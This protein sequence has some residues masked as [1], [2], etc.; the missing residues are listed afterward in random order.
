MA[1]KFRNIG[2]GTSSDDKDILELLRELEVSVSNFVTSDIFKRDIFESSDENHYTETF[3]KFF[4]NT[5]INSR[6]SLN[7]QVSLPKRRS[8]DI[9]IYLKAD[10]EHYIFNIEAKFLPSRDYVSGN[11][12]AIER[13][14][15]CVHGLSNRNP[16]KCKLL[17][18]SSIIAYKRN[19]EFSSHQESINKEIHNLSVNESEEANNWEESEKLKKVY[20]KDTARL[21]SIHKRE[22]QKQITLHHFWVELP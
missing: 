21:K 11:Y 5:Y 6:F 14:K 3:V 18:Q 16:E 1:I 8:A 9:G 12:S 22:N 7:Q 20:F 4:E 13:F 15:K 17:L 10:S 2:E 19:G